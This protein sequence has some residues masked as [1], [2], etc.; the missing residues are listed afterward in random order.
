VI[1]V[2]AVARSFGLPV[3]R[4]GAIET[5]SE[6]VEGH[7]EADD[8]E[9][10]RAPVGA[11]VTHANERGCE[12]PEDAEVIGHHPRRQPGR[13]PL[14]DAPLRAREQRR[15]GANVGAGFSHHA[16]PVVSGGRTNY[17]A[18][19]VPLAARESK[20]VQ[21]PESRERLPV[22]L[23]SRDE[24]IEAGVLPHLADRIL[25]HREAHGPIRDENE[26][27]LLVRDNEIR[28]DQLLGVVTVTES[29]E[30]RQGYST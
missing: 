18:R 20:E 24:L 25:A 10:V 7:C 22:N 9:P 3:A 4:N 8:P 11:G 29:G 1:Q 23:A 28:L 30:V 16:D 2:I 17:P 21:M 15:I 12:Q 6:P 5:V 13:Q 27:Y 14:E 26:L 19:I